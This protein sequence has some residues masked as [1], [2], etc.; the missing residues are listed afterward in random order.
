MM[1][2][3]EFIHFQI[4][5]PTKTCLKKFILDIKN[6]HLLMVHPGHSDEK[7]SKIDPVTTSRDIEYEFLS[8][9]NF[10]D[11]LNKNNIVLKKPIYKIIILN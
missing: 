3:L 4:K 5:Y 10:L 9:D 2:F 1:V 6:N 11:L 7:L 8:S